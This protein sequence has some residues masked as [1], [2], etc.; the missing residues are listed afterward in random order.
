MQKSLKTTSSISSMPTLPVILPMC[1]M[2]ILNSSAARSNTKSASSGTEVKSSEHRKGE[3]GGE[4][5]EREQN[6][7]VLIHNKTALYNR[8]K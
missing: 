8:V 6:N 2:A 1:L 5:G 3:E 7:F 4:E